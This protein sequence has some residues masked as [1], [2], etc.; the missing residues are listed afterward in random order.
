MILS[1]SENARR[2]DRILLDRIFSPNPRRYD[3]A[4]LQVNVTEKNI[5][6][7]IAEEETP[8][9]IEDDYAAFFAAYQ[10]SIAKL[11]L[12]D[13]VHQLTE[14]TVSARRRTQTQEIFQNRSTSI[15]YYDVVSEIDDVYDSGE[16]VGKDI[17]E[18]LMNMNENFSTIRNSVGR[19]WIFYKSRMALIV[20]NY[21]R[22]NWDN[23]IEI[24]K[25][26]TVPLSAIKSIYINENYS[27]IS[28]YVWHPYDLVANM[29]NCVVFIE[30]YPE[31]ERPAEA[32]KG[33]R[34]TWLEGYS[35]VSE[36]YSPNYSGLPPIL[37]DYRRTLY[38]NPTVTTD[39]NGKANIQFYNNSSSR[40]F[41]ISAETV[42][43]QG[44]V[45]IYKDK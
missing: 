17:H 19:E 23:F 26:E 39:E 16:F 37:P 33:V 2:T 35:G 36:F 40:N 34:K 28:Q 45:G 38:W 7:I 6:T 44:M 43:Q 22:I 4:E 21:Q 42:T 30:T 1:I 20:V 27:A 3:Y 32:A 25:Y 5:V 15:A 8:E 14:V 29:F 24:I 12:A 9:E 11:G 13:R 18:L 31:G 41:S 10:D